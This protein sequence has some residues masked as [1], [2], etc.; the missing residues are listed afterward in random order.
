V[1]TKAEYLG[2][3]H[4]GIF[5]LANDNLCFAPLSCPLELEAAISEHLQVD[6]IKVSMA[7]TGLLGIFSSMNNKLLITT[8]ILEKKEVKALEDYIEV[9]VLQNRY[10]AIGNLVTMND[11]GIA[12]TK[13]LE[14]HIEGSTS[15][16]ISDSDLVGSAV[17]ANNRG[18][19]VHR[20][21]YIEDIFKLED[22]FKVKGDV[23]TVNM[24]NPFVK[25]GIFG[26]K[27]GMIAGSLTS[28]PEL[29][30][31]EDIFLFSE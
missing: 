5:C 18:F 19:L 8:E 31:I 23:G 25:S 20:D 21:A 12:C 22:I 15:L 29:N 16:N 10:T 26:N 24:G 13:A 1:I 14:K 6:V 7:G 27:N 4:V 30:R 3:P 28:G 9:M 11:K 17:F 2:S